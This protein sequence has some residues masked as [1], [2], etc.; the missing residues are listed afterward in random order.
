MTTAGGGSQKFARFASRRS[1]VHSTKGMVACS[2]PLAAEA[3]QRILK[4]GG[5]AADAAVAVAAALNV[6]EPASTGLG[7]DAFCLFFDSASKLV[8]ALNGSGRSARDTSLDQVKQDLWAA[9][10]GDARKIPLTSPFA[11]TTPGAAALWVDA[12]DRFGSSKLTLAQILEPAIELAEEGFPVSE[13]SA[14][15]WQNAESQLKKASPNFAEILVHDEAASQGARAP[16]AGEI[17]QNRSLA[18]TLRTLAAKGKPGFYTG[19]VAQAVVEIVQ[20]KGGKLDLLDLQNHLEE[21]IKEAEAISLRFS[22]FGVGNALPRGLGDK[23]FVEL[24]EHPPNGQGIVALMALRILQELEATGKIQ[25]FGPDEH[26][27]A[28]YLHATIEALQIALADAAWWVTD[29]DHSPVHPEELTSRSYL[30][31]RAKLFDPDKAGDHTHSNLGLSPAQNHSDTVYFAVTDKDGNG[32]SFVNSV[33][34]EFGSGLVPKGCGFT[35]Q[36]RGANFDLAP[37][38]HPN[39]YRGGKRPY[40]TI[41]PGLV[42]QGEGA[43]RQLHSVYGVM[44]G[45][46]QPQGHVQVLLNTEVFGLNPQEAL[47]APRFCIAAAPTNQRGVVYLEEGIDEAVVQKLRAK[48]HRIEVL[49]DFDRV[50]FGRGQLIRQ[51]QDQK[52]GKLVFSAGSDGRGDG[53]ALPG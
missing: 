5:N 14:R 13:I 32:M 4:L 18:Q 1:V 49:C 19:P 20:S 29:P 44:G 35:L 38:N 43:D 37:D 34:R 39:I 3:G 25:S 36:N 45:L 27:T 9:G 11:V 24:W 40:H 17:S 6:T 7:G 41:I 26:N 16:R 21:G 15:M 46:M 48:G 10:A 52:T 12:V 22:G 53:L 47:D 2:Q 51:R 30:S 42:T 23:S 8:H 31:E 33:F 50:W 28:R